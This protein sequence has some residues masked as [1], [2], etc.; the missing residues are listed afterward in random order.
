[1]AEVGVEPQRLFDLLYA[2]EKGQVELVPGQG[3]VKP[4]RLPL[5]T[6]SCMAILHSGHPSEIVM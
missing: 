4:G 6:V 3:S 1:M 2:G 5:N